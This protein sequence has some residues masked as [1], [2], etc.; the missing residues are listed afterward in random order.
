M[1]PNVPEISFLC[2]SYEKKKTNTRE[3]FGASLAV[4]QVDVA[5]FDSSAAIDFGIGVA[6]RQ[7]SLGKTGNEAKL[8]NRGLG[9]GVSPNVE[10]VGA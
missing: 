6:V 8:S 7:V 10:S 4:N 3:K 1:E 2:P 5:S 9:R